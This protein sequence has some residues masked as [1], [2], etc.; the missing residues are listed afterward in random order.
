[1]APLL[2]KTTSLIFFP[3]CSTKISFIFPSILT[4]FHRDVDL[5]LS[6]RD[7]DLNVRFLLPVD[8]LLG[9]TSFMSLCTSL[10]SNLKI[11]ATVQ[12][13]YINY[14]TKEEQISRNEI[15]P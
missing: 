1:M 8:N 3:R 6:I 5:G 13:L 2:T 15:F 11:N 9:H 4:D 7:L 14:N 12:A 10:S